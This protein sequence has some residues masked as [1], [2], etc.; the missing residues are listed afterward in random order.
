[1]KTGCR[2][3]AGLM[4]AAVLVAPRSGSAQVQTLVIGEGGVDWIDSIEETIGVDTTAA[5]AGTIQPFELDPAVNIASGPATENGNLTNTFGEVWGFRR[6]SAGLSGTA[7]LEVTTDGS[8]FIYGSRGAGQIVD[9]DTL[10][11]SDPDPIAHYSIDLG[12][13]LPIRRVSWFSPPKGRTS[14]RQFSGQLIKDLFPRQYVLS[15]SLNAAEFLTTPTSTNFVDV[16]ENNP[17]QVDRVAN[18]RFE[19]Q[20]MR[21]VRARFPTRGFIAEME[22]YGEGFVPGIS[23]VSRLFDMGEPVNFGRLHHEFERFETTGFG[24]EHVLTPDAPVALAV[25]TRSG[26]DDTPL[27]H[28]VV[29]ELGTEWIVDITEFNRAPAPAGGSTNAPGQQ[30]SVLDDVDN[31][32]FWSASQLESGEAIRAPDGRQF[33]Q[34]RAFMTSQ[35]VF[36]YGRLRSMTVEF[37]PLLANPVFAEVALLDEPTPEDGVV[38]V[39]LGE[40][41]TL[42][43]DVR[44]EFTSASQVGFDG[45]RLNTPE[46]VEFQRFEMGEPLAEV[47]PDSMR[48]RD[49]S[50]ELY[51]PSNPVR[52]GTNVPLRLTF[53]TRVFNFSTLFE[54]EV[55]QIGGENLPQSIDGGDASDAVS[56]DGLIVIAPLNRL[57]VLSELVIPSSVVTPNGDGHNDDL[58][59]SYS[60]HGVQS[61]KVEAAIHDL[62]GRVV[63]RLVSDTRGEGRYTETWDSTA[64]GAMVAPGTYLLRVAVD[65]DLGTFEQTRVLAVAY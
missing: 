46:P 58:Q 39:P 40:P 45:L 43:Y 27:I 20:F 63:H 33:F 25:Q 65:T 24:T 18:V 34:V 23:Y 64:G 60:L 50:F 38:E 21:Y 31:W 51:F 3:V 54:G 12:F 41:V 30:G 14:S 32:S 44:A 9:G 10:L 15:A 16:I 29:T 62:S 47:Q 13:P 52:Q 2:V 1:M 61:A 57:E 4:I 22:F 53:A 49:E 19:P 7:P 55:F 59:L 48:V 26:R 8:P 28:H 5:A 11:P 56:T 42:T 37:S 35:D 6:G 36:S 17:N